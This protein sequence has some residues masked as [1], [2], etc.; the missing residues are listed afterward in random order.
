VV[1]Q[2]AGLRLVTELAEAPT[3]ATLV[4]LAGERQAEGIV[5][6]A[7]GCGPVRAMLGVSHALLHEM[8]RPTVVVPAAMLG[9]L[10]SGLPAALWWA[11]TGP[12]TA[13]DALAHAAYR[14]GRGGRLVVVYVFDPPRGS[15][16]TPSAVQASADSLALGEGVHPVVLVP[17]SRWP[18]R[19][20]GSDARS[21]QCGCAAC[22]GARD[23]G[24]LLGGLRL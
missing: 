5:V 4:R 7:R 12:P 6:G 24:G 16:P 2:A 23:S 13:K 3:A 21:G 8:D 9:A 10:P 1:G 19:R 17:Q 20:S 11:T 22:L 15:W 18:S 14:P